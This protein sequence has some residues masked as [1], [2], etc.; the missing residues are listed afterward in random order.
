MGVPFRLAA[1]AEKKVYAR[2]VVAMNFRPSHLFR[3]LTLLTYGPTNAAKEKACSVGRCVEAKYCD[4]AQATAA[5]PHLVTAGVPCQPFSAFRQKSGST[6]GTGPPKAHGKF[7]ACL[8]FVEYVLARR[9]WGFIIEQV[10]GILDVDPSTGA[11][12]L[13]GILSPL[14]EAGYGSAWAVLDLGVWLTVDRT[15]T[16]IDCLF[17]RA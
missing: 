11:P 5:R 6:A 12:Y 1:A 10:K 7:F 8:D 4:F 15:R 17:K 14:A 3:C 13:E 16:D 2:K 9:P